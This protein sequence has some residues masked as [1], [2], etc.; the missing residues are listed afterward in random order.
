M[1]SVRA[2]ER[3]IKKSLV[4]TQSVYIKPLSYLRVFLL[5]PCPSCS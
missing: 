1:S 4:L 2:Q 5:L 3:T